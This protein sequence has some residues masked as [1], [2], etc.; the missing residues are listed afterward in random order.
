VYDI[1][2]APEL[3]NTYHPVVRAGAEL[4]AKAK[5]ITESPKEVKVITVSGSDDRV[6]L[7][8]IRDHGSLKQECKEI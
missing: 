4:H 6:L 2:V 7:F 8:E 5:N 1:Y 3:E